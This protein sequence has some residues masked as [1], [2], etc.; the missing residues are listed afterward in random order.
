MKKCSFTLYSGSILC[1]VLLIM[2]VI[3]PNSMMAKNYHKLIEKISVG[4]DSAQVVQVAGDPTKFIEVERFFY[5]LDQVVISDN[6]VIDIRIKQEIKPTTRSE[7]KHKEQKPISRL[8][9]GMSREEVLQNAGSPTLNEPGVDL[10]FSDRHRVELKEGKVR[11]V[12]M[13][14]KIEMEILD[15]IRLNFSKGGLLFMNIT[16]AFIMFGVALEIKLKHFKEIIRK[17]KSAIIGVISQFIALPALTFLLV[18]ILKP[19]PSVA[20]GMI[21]VAACPGGNISNFISSLSKANIELSVSL[22]AFATLSAIILTPLNFAFWGNLYSGT[23]DMVVPIKIDVWE[24]MQTVF[25]LLGIPIVLG[26]W[27]AH[28]FPVI[29]SKIIKP[30]KWF[31]LLAFMGFILAAF[32]SNFQFFLDY[33]HFILLIVFIHNLLALTTGFSLATLFG[34]PKTDRRTLTIE[35]GIQNS[36]LGLVLIFNPNLFDGL[37]GM[38]FIAAWWGIWHIISGLLVASFWSRKPIIRE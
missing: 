1:G 23:A 30:L 5:N 2:L 24:M 25:I 22:T 4:M 29:T 16:L 6:E 9:I 34:L 28:K 14:I 33:I 8:R 10:Y 26:T 38:A 20:L 21:L 11:E 18:I 17:P 19:T 27:F 3:M 32:A 35:T 13:H 31:S 36:G 37:G 12:E 15:W 7:R